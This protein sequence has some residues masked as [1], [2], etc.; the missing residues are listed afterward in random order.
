MRPNSQN[1]TYASW[2]P[3]LVRTLINSID[4]RDHNA[5]FRCGTTLA[6]LSK[7]PISKASLILMEKALPFL[8]RYID[9]VNLSD[10][11][12]Y[13]DEIEEIFTDD[14][15]SKIS[16]CYGVK[17]PKKNKRFKTRTTAA[18]PIVEEFDSDTDKDVCRRTRVVYVHE[19]VLESD[20]DGFAA[21]AGDILPAGQEVERS[22][23]KENA[24]CLIYKN[25]YGKF[26]TVLSPLQ[27]LSHAL[28][29]LTR[30]SVQINVF[31]GIVFLRNFLLADRGISLTK[32]DDQKYM[33]ITWFK[34]QLV[35]SLCTQ[36]IGTLTSVVPSVLGI[37]AELVYDSVLRALILRLKE[38]TDASKNFRYLLD[39]PTSFNDC[40]ISSFDDMLQRTNEVAL[41]LLKLI[42]SVIQ[43]SKCHEYL[44]QVGQCIVSWGSDP[45]FVDY[46]DRAFTLIST[47]LRVSSNSSTAGARFA[48]ELFASL[49]DY[50]ELTRYLLDWCLTFPSGFHETVT[51]QE[52]ISVLSPYLDEF[53]SVVCN[54]L[55][56]HLPVMPWNTCS[57]NASSY[58]NVVSGSPSTTVINLVQ[59]ISIDGSVDILVQVCTLVLPH[60]DNSDC[61]FLLAECVVPA[62]EK[63]CELCDFTNE[64]L[65]G[66]NEMSKDVKDLLKELE[67]LAAYLKTKSAAKKVITAIVIPH[68][69]FYFFASEL[70]DVFVAVCSKAARLAADMTLDSGLCEWLVDRLNSCT[71][72]ISTDVWVLMDDSAAHFSKILISNLNIICDILEENPDVFSPFT[73]RLLAYASKLL[74]LCFEWMTTPSEIYRSIRRV[75][76]VTSKALSIHLLLVTDTVEIC[77]KFSKSLYKALTKSRS[78]QLISCMICSL[79]EKCVS[80]FPSVMGSLLSVDHDSE[81]DALMGD[82]GPLA[83]VPPRSILHPTLVT[84]VIELTSNI[85]RIFDELDSTLEFLILKICKQLQ[86]IDKHCGK[87]EDWLASLFVLRDAV[88]QLSANSDIVYTL[89]D[90]LGLFIKRSPSSAYLND[91]VRDYFEN[92]KY[93]EVVLNSFIKL[94]SDPPSP[95]VSIVFP[96]PAIRSPVEIKTEA[97]LVEETKLN[98][99]ETLEK[100]ASSNTMLDAV[101]KLLTSNRSD[102]EFESEQRKEKKKHLRKSTLALRKQQSSTEVSTTSASSSNCNGGAATFTLGNNHSVTSADGLTLSFW[103]KRELLSRN[104]SCQPLPIASIG[105]DSLSCQVLLTDKGK[106]VLDIIGFPLKTIS[107]L[108][109]KG[110]MKEK[111]WTHFAL[112]MRALPN[113]ITIQ[114]CVGEAWSLYEVP[115]V[116]K[117]DN[118][119]FPMTI[120]FGCVRKKSQHIYY[121]SSLFG[122]KGLLGSSNL[123][124]LSGL[125]CQ[126]S[127]LAETQIQH[128]APN[129]ASVITYRAVATKQCFLEPVARD[130]GKFVQKLQRSLVVIVPASSAHSYGVS[131][132]PA[133]VEPAS[134]VGKSA[135]RLAQ[136]KEYQILWLSRLDQQFNASIDE[137]LIP[138][139]G[140]KFIIYIFVKAVNDGLSKQTQRA[141]LGLLLKCLRRDCIYTIEADRVKA[142][143]VIARTLSSPLAICDESTLD[144]LMRYCIRWTPS[145]NE[146]SKDADSFS[147]DPYQAV[148]QEPK[149]IAL[150]SCRCELWRKDRFFVYRKFISHL[151]DV[152][153]PQTCKV[154]AAFNRGQLSSTDMLPKFLHCLLEMI[155]D[156][157]NFPDF[158]FETSFANSVTLVV[159]SLL[160]IPELPLSV[161][162][163]WHFIFLSHPANYTY[164]DHR[165]LG[166]SEWLKPAYIRDSPEGELLVDSRLCKELKSIISLLG[167]E[168]VNELWKKGVSP[169]EIRRLYQEKAQQYSLDTESGADE[170]SPDLDVLDNWSSEDD[171]T[172]QQLKEP[173]K[174]E[175]AWVVCLRASLMK[176]LSNVLQNGADSLMSCLQHDVISWHAIV[177]LLSH[178]DDIRIR[179]AAFDLLQKFLLRSPLYTKIVFL[180]LSGFH[181]LGSQLR[182]GPINFKIA[183]NLFSLMCGETIRLGDGLDQAHLTSMEVDSFSCDSL[184]A[185]LIAFEQSVPDAPLFWNIA[186]ALL[187]TFENCSQLQ[188][189]MISAGLVDCMVNV[190]RRI[191][192]TAPT[193]QYDVVSTEGQDSSLQLEAWC[194]FAQRII[195]LAIPFSDELLGNACER[196]VWLLLLADIQAAKDMR[197]SE[198][199]RLLAHK[200]IRSQL[201]MVLFHYI[202]SVQ[203]VFSDEGKSASATSS[204]DSLCNQ[205]NSSTTSSPS[206]EYDYCD[207]LITPERATNLDGTSP[208]AAF[209]AGS[210][211]NLREKISLMGPI[212]K[213]SLKCSFS[214]KV[215]PAALATIDVLTKRVVFALDSVSILFT[216]LIP[217]YALAEEES[218]LFHF[219]MYFL[220]TSWK[221][222]TVSRTTTQ[223]I[224]NRLILFT[225]DKCRIL[226]AQLVAFLLFP[227]HKKI[228][229]A[230]KSASLRNWNKEWTEDQRFVIIRVLSHELNSKIALPSLL[231]VNLDYEYALCLGVYELAFVSPPREEYKSEIERMVRFLQNSK[232]G[233]N[234]ERFTLESL[235]NLNTEEILSMH[236]YSQYRKTVLAQLRSKTE[237]ILEE[238]AKL[239]ADVG[240]MAMTVTCEVV[241]EQNLPRKVFIRGSKTAISDFVEAENI[242]LAIAKELCHPESS[243]FETRHW[244]VGWA[245][246]P[247][248]GPVRERRRLAPFYFPFEP[249]FF[250]DEKKRIV[251]ENKEEAPLQKLLSIPLS[252]RST[253]ENAQMNEPIKVFLEVT[254]LRVTFECKGDLLI[255]ETGVYFVGDTAKSTQKGTV[256]S[257]ITL[258]WKFDQIKEIHARN[259]LLNDI[260]YEI[261]TS[262]G[263]T[264]LIV[265]QNAQK[266]QQFKSS[267]LELHLD[268]LFP[269]TEQQIACIVSAWRN[270]NLSNFEY[271]MYLNKFAGRSFNDLMQYPVFPFILSDYTSSILNLHNSS[272]YRILSKP[273]AIQDK[274]MESHY[275]STYNCLQAECT[276]TSMEAGPLHFGPYHYG[277]HY[278]NSGIVVHYLVRLSP[279]T[280]IALE[281]QDNN[282]DI[283]DRLFNSIESTWR[284][285][286]SEST[287]DFKE[288]IPEF[289][290]L[291]EFL[292]NRENLRLGVRQA[293]EEVGDVRLPRWTPE[294]NARLFILI[295]RQALESQY[296]TQNL[297]SWIDL[298][299]GFK[300]TGKA[301]LEA[302]NVFHPATYL[303]RLNADELPDELAQ[304]ALRTM[305]KSY[306]Q[307]PIQIFNS[308]LQS[309]SNTKD[310]K[311][312]SKCK[313]PVPTVEGVRWGDYVGSPEQDASQIQVV[314]SVKGSKADRLGNVINLPDG[315]SVGVPYETLIVTT[316][317]PENPKDQLNTSCSIITLG[318]LS[319]SFSD[320]I[321]RFRYIKPEVEPWVNLICLGN[322]KVSCMEYS[323][324][325]RILFL[326][327]TNGLIRLYK[328]ELID[329]ENVNITQLSD[330]IAH[331]SAI[332]CFSISDEFSVAISGDQNGKVVLWDTNRL[333]FVRVLRQTKS[334][335][336]AL[337]ISSTSG[338][339]A[340]VSQ[341]GYGSY[342][343][344]YSINGDL[345]GS[346]KTDTPV[347]CVTMT[348]Q[349][350]GTAI[351]CMALGML[352]GHILLCE[353]WC[354]T[355]VQ[356]I[357]HENHH[358][359][360]RS[361]VYASG[362]KKLYAVQAT[363][364]VLCWQTVA[365]IS[366]GKTAK[367][368]FINPHDLTC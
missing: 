304:S 250:K 153:D 287:T 149:F 65:S 174:P 46:I 311:E 271:L 45:L 166:H 191:A 277:S 120:S 140:I 80:R 276:R 200:V 23:M 12:R 119:V 100:S 190:L 237:A 214:K 330:L 367:F 307:M 62:I 168:E 18:G 52:L 68:R 239:T 281:Y 59:S 255:G 331:H 236:S 44:S 5:R 114:A 74:D 291:P 178:Q 40:Y 336:T 302:L 20:S 21:F 275:I 33:F 83:H 169:F 205:T 129:L 113:L 216:V 25:L 87:G 104:S 26:P 121:L 360:I 32:G 210:F 245:L 53:P 72:H 2:H 202:E 172:N 99:L 49:I 306:G 347:T 333:C 67:L 212:S 213:K 323:S 346:V 112:G 117:L 159:Q 79:L 314:L 61:D 73:D 71:R 185:I 161:A 11:L 165:V 155:Q 273:M 106:L 139:G 335:V 292:Y 131:I 238:E 365:S 41:R 1:F 364:R 349:K 157:D 222:D 204:I 98:E 176:L 93:K 186:N 305:V 30:F 242:L 138:L 225:R 85:L 270:G 136:I 274:R 164:I 107:R 162:H 207:D 198:S 195:Q 321:L 231:N 6:I 28:V 127:S 228:Q 295:H 328:L 248:E 39:D 184:H 288:L 324:T 143:L 173:S 29:V 19:C 226:L 284:L 135:M 13:D 15:F 361:L 357:C 128:L 57:K 215:G 269:N 285:S 56:R 50:S 256:C 355:I 218:N 82:G 227:A 144:V 146:E 340:V 123:L 278:S 81:D 206:E 209:F 220:L 296:V 51:G 22:E 150:L 194:S 109:L 283:P 188:Q 196:F 264:Y 132:I 261:F 78:S 31:A 244:P 241:E 286:S 152:L 249:R 94:F 297:H 354:L 183:D 66:T 221:K 42:L 145:E 267:L 54:I 317:V 130:I 9:S 351:N 362:G 219:Y 319:Y 289:F 27:C 224:W 124:A 356:D 338:D 47:E 243:A 223:T 315:A 35:L 262:N 211:A 163:L 293:G 60:C 137:H 230:S 337:C 89:H 263:D 63:T 298:I 234:F 97:E 260:A 105:G 266:R 95:P 301:A 125:G 55:K 24:M 167:E 177:V 64:S 312:K 310:K 313:S 171:L 294:G 343:E 233:S 180:R 189:A 316:S 43:I 103:I 182:G 90:L 300:Q 187:K 290:C 348:N 111:S 4:V 160:G 350:E 179:E 359:P 279:F 115:L 342:V 254:V 110:S 17:K 368:T 70:Q 91:F 339:V 156:T 75:A 332:N 318:A 235:K 265:F 344:L 309:C 303:G 116:V 268:H 48:F 322:K 86:V 257:V 272:S 258:G 7:I 352:D 252:S 3:L 246:D 175:R 247:T 193:A 133:D 259:H 366:R 192:Y 341:Q 142:H 299:F 58:L 96:Q 199:I 327:F 151:S 14:V 201:C 229:E 154:P 118:P 253:F 320:S 76:E 158:T 122:F 141:A 34:W 102:E 88:V 329:N 148:I 84:T 16:E 77:N 126:L 232:T 38:N 37:E 282:F 8:I 147:L 134:L 69:D 325:N 308:A 10:S 334:A 36:C 353:M 217:T 170:N 101:E 203:S 108:R 280:Q 240:G 363:G 251:Q 181:I 345:I 197:Y 92:E 326:S 358:D 208:L